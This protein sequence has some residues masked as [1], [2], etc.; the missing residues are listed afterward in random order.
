MGAE[1]RGSE[2]RVPNR[3]LWLDVKVERVGQGDGARE[4]Q[5]G[6]GL[7][8]APEPHNRRQTN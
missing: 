2:P 7:G 1:V 5:L 4:L 6:V 3:R 8:K